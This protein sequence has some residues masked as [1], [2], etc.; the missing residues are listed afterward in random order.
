V[1]NVLVNDIRGQ[2]QHTFKILYEEIGRFNAQQWLTGL[3]DPDQFQVPVKLAMHIFDCL[4]FYFS[5][6]DNYTWGHQFGGG[7]WELSTTQLPGTAAVIDYAKTLEAR[8][9][10]YLASLSDED[11]VRPAGPAGAPGQTLLGHLIYAAR[12]TVHHHG[13]LAALNVFNGNPGGCWD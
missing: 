6:G 11:L 3:P 13:E 5:K 10:D 4:D 12:H 7:W 8:I 2:Y 1:A 9:D